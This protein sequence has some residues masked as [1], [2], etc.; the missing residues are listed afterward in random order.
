MP[1]KHSAILIAVV[2]VLLL[3]GSAVS[4]TLPDDGKW[5]PVLLIAGGAAIW[6]G[7][8]KYKWAH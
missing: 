8:N 6:F 2:G 4:L 1:T 3:I 5:F 7:A